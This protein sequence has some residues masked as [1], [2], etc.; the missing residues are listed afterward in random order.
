MVTAAS[1]NFVWLAVGHSYREATTISVLP[2]NILLEIFCF[3]KENDDTPYFPWDWNLL[4]HVCRRWRQIVFSSP[5]RLNLRIFCTSRSPAGKYL[6][7]WPV[8]PISIDFD[9]YTDRNHG[10]NTSS[11]DNIISVLKH[12]DR[13]CDVRL[14][15]TH[16]ELEKITTVMQEPFPALT[17][18]QIRL[19][20]K[21]KDGN[22]SVLPAEFLG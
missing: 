8:L 21:S 19:N 22:V 3:Y 9:Y 20:S 1:T 15:A 5:L 11:E 14:N 16:S 2:D 6:G 18:L 12:V 4:V 7:I 13:I 17:T 10:N